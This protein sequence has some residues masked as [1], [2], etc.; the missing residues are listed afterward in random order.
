M[1]TSAVYFLRNHR[2]NH[3]LYEMVSYTNY[4]NS[5]K[6]NKHKYHSYFPIAEIRFKFFAMKYPFQLQ[7]LD[8]ENK[9]MI[10]RLL[11]SEYNH[12]EMEMYDSD[13]IDYFN[14]TTE[15]NISINFNNHKSDNLI[16][17]RRHRNRLYLATHN[18]PVEK[19]A[20]KCNY[21]IPVKTNV[22]IMEKIKLGSFMTEFENRIDVLLKKHKTNSSECVN[23]NPVPKLYNSTDEQ[24]IHSLLSINPLMFS[25]TSFSGSYSL[26]PKLNIIYHLYNV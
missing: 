15:N 14:L 6:F 10:E 26:Q 4:T 3:N 2:C 20:E 18:F 11:S 7:N 17:S 5:V 19:Y 1:R 13:D 12:K 22:I 23:I 8:P 21:N 16:P 9:K 25:E 24:L